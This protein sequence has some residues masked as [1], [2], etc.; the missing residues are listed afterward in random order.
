MESG[1]S[2][3][4]TLMKSSS[5][6]TNIPKWRMKPMAEYSYKDIITGK[7]II[8][9]QVKDSDIIGAEGYFAGDLKTIVDS[10]DDKTFPDSLLEGTLET[11]SDVGRFR[12]KEDG[13]YFDYF[14]RKKEAAKRYVPFD[15]SDAVVREQLWGKRIVIDDSYTVGETSFRRD[16]HSI[17]TGFIFCM[18]GEPKDYWMIIAGDCTLTAEEALER[19]HFYDET[20][21]GKLVEE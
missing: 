11:V 12:R 14:I 7:D 13:I 21:C 8:T 4:N 16:V 1:L 17:I 5:M 19:A 20:P 10:F 18:D 9:D 6:T 15:L 3:A 2:S